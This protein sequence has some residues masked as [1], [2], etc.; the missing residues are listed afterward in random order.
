MKVLVT[1]GAGFIGSHLVDRLIELEHQVVIV[2]DLSH[3][4]REYI[5]PKARF[6]NVD[7]RSKDLE[8]IF[9]E[10]KPEVVFH[11]AAQISVPKSLDNP[12]MDAEI[13]IIGT[14]NLLEC[15]KKHNVRKII[16]P[17]SAAIFGEPE[18]LPIDEKHPLNMISGYGITKHTVEHYLQVYSV[19]YGI[20]YTVLRYANVYGPRQDSTGEGGVVSIFCERMLEG[21]KIYIFG[22][23]EQ[24]RD[25]VYVKDVVDANIL[26]M[27]NLKNDIFN[28]C[29]NSKIS[30]NNLFD[31]ISSIIDDSLKPIYG[32]ERHGDIR[33]SYMTFEKIRNKGNWEPKYS[34]E[35]GIK[36]TINFYKG[37]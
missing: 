9:S 16:Y 37:L 3:G 32:E 8:K 36:E 6:Y 24:T 19:L 10:E 23:G 12:I 11:E 31:L 28:V 2:D 18:Y 27:N 35:E 25:F 14:I 13:N 20:E 15:S 17:A 1:G 21:Q 30:V 22:D 26:A 4:K 5:N 29:T 34:L 7:I 33:H